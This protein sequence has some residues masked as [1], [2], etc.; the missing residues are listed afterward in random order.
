MNAKTNL[1]V[2]LIAGLAV[3]ILLF[4]S[5]YVRYHALEGSLIA[6][7]F[8]DYNVYYAGYGDDDPDKIAD[9]LHRICTALGV[10]E[11]MR[12]LDAGVPFDDVI[13]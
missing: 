3:G 6:A 9:D 5:T 11:Q 12:A 7:A 1:T 8:A 4:L 2:S 10:D 13:A